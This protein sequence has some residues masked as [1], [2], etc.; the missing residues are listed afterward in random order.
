MMPI[1]HLR[2]HYTNAV[3][4]LS[5]PQAKYQTFTLKK[6]TPSLRNCSIP[7]S[8]LCVARDETLRESYK[9]PSADLRGEGLLLSEEDGEL[10]KDHET[11]YDDS[12]WEEQ[13][14]ENEED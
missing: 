6:N 3:F 1:G 4:H 11:D 14:F 7:Y 8:S 10:E 5:D 2:I 13:E 9:N 12:L